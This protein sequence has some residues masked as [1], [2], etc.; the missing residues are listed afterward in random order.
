LV[1]YAAHT[2]HIGFYPAYKIVNEV[3]KDKLTDF[4]TSKGTIKFPYDKK[5]PLQLIKEIVKYKTKLNLEKVKS[6]RKKNK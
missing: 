2:N 6:K 1:Y 3:F 4:E 5:M